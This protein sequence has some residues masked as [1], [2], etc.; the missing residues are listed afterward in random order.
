MSGKRDAAWARAM[1]FEGKDGK[2]D[3]AG[4]VG[5]HQQRRGR[6]ATPQGKAKGKDV[7]YA[8]DTGKSGPWV[9]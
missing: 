8:E 2:R 3:A 5:R 6:G 4:A 7:Y 1:G 9:V